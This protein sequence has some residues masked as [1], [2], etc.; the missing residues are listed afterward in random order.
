MDAVAGRGQPVAVDLVQVLVGNDRPSVV[1][2][3]R[4]KGVT[5]VPRLCGGVQSD[6]VKLV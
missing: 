4:C 6:R 1:F 3:S 5:Q 2:V